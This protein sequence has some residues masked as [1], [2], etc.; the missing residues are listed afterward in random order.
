MMPMKNIEPQTGDGSHTP[1]SIRKP[2]NSESGSLLPDIS[3]FTQPTDRSGEKKPARPLSLRLFPDSVLREECSPV[4]RF[5]GWLQDVVAEMFDLMR[6]HKGIG[7]AAP[8]VGITQSFFIA[9]MDGR[10]LCLINP[11]IV[12][13]FGRDRRKEGCL[14]LPDVFVDLERRNC[15]EVTGYDLLGQK[16]QEVFRGLWARMILHETDHLKGIL[17]CDYMSRFEDSYDQVVCR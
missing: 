1:F 9:E 8:Q 5:D 14:S 3:I 15:T 17:L 12:S 2:S 6:K 11:A 13:C 7:L 10:S 4:E 16:R